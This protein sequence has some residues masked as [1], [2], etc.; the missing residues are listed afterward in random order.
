VEP[1]IALA[2][3]LVGA[4]TEVAVYRENRPDVAV[5]VD[6]FGKRAVGGQKRGGKQKQAGEK[7]RSDCGWMPTVISHKSAP[8]PVLRPTYV[9]A[10]LLS[11][12]CGRLR[13]PLFHCN[14]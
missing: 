7:R 4:V 5:E 12:P 14:R 3:V 10:H 13:L 2:L 8:R 9:P 6:R 1:Q 11:T